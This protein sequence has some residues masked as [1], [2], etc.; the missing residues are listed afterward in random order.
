M[1]FLTALLV[2]LS[3]TAFAQDPAEYFN[4]FDNKVYSLKTKGVKDFVVDITSSKLTEQINDQKTFGLVKKVIFRTYWTANPERLAIE[5]I[6]MPEGFQEAKESLKA[7]ILP[8]M[9]NV[10]P[11]TMTQRFP[12]YKFT[13]GSKPKEFIATDT[14]GIAP[15]PS[16]VIRF[17][18]QDRLTQIIGNRPVGTSSMDLLYEKKAFTDGKWALTLAT[19]TASENGQTITSSRKVNYGT[20][21]GMGIVSSVVLTT[22]QK[23]ENPKLKPISQSDEV[24]FENY[25][26]NS[27]EAFKFFLGDAD[28][29][30]P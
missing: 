30:A 24:K 8:L 27:G 9:D 3:L 22:E 18:N 28:K 4:L 10:L 25:K 13:A 5:V 15:I 2:L 19:N 23:W 11:M 7:S 1:K 17:D 29:P 6:G 12:G 20:S 26:I 16:Y 14:T 21:Q